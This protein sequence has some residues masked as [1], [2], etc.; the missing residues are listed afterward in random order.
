MKIINENNLLKSSSNKTFV[1][2]AWCIASEQQGG[3]F[4]LIPEDGVTPLYDLVIGGHG[5]RLAVGVESF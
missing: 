2:R 1:T 3:N 5:E 4:S